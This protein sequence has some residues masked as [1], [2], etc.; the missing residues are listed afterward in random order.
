MQNAR[1]FPCWQIWSVINLVLA[2]EA[3]GVK[4][5]E[6]TY[7]C[8]SFRH[9]EKKK[10]VGCFFHFGTGLDTQSTTISMS[11]KCRKK[12]FHWNED[13]ELSSVYY[14]L[15]G[16]QSFS[17]MPEANSEGRAHIFSEVLSSDPLCGWENIFSI[18]S[19]PEQILRSK[20]KD[21]RDKSW[22]KAYQNF[23]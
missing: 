18:Q 17:R 12:Q 5:Q 8:N 7:L 15:R 19:M 16:G 6:S 20:S 22:I 14:I 10:E 13:I 3:S 1:I 2:R 21:T 11:R 9:P 4:G 23:V